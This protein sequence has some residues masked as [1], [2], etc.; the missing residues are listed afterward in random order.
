M[1]QQYILL[2][3]VLLIFTI[4]LMKFIIVIKN[5]AQK[6]FLFSPILSSFSLKNIQTPNI[7]SLKK[8]RHDL[9]IFIPYFVVI[10]FLTGQIVEKKLG[11]S[12]TAYFLIPATYLW[13]QVLPLLSR[14]FFLNRKVLYPPMH[15]E[16]LQ[17]KSLSDFWGKRWNIWF[18]TW[19]REVFFYPFAHYPKLSTLSVFLMSGLWH[20]LIFS[21][22]YYGITGINHLG[23]MLC[24]F[25]LQ[26]LGVFL[27]QTYLK[28]IKPLPRKIF[29]WC[30]VIAPA[31]LYLHSAI[32][33]FFTMVKL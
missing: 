14:F 27:D 16:P 2:H 23:K 3:F 4:Y 29:L 24:Y 22:P 1:I 32:E 33:P 8:M 19:F 6:K 18:G 30:W 17:A 10:Y 31:P 12:F 11:G 25:T 7:L 13:L 15:D 20:E 5:G 28:N 26:A 9:F 21:L